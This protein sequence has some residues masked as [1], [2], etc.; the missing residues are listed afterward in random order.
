MSIRKIEENRY[1]IDISLGYVKGKQKRH[2]V[3]FDGS[4][5]YAVIYEIE[6]ARQLGKPS[7]EKRTIAGFSDEYLEWAK[8]H[9][10]E[11]TYKDKKKI[12]FSQIIPFFGNMKPDFITRNVLEAYQTKRVSLK[13][14]IHRAINIELCCL[15]AMTVWAKDHG[16]CIDTLVRIKPLPYKRPIPKVLSIEE[17]V[18]FIQACPPVY[19]AYFLGLYHC[20]M[21]SDEAKHLKWTDIIFDRDCIIVRG[22]GNKERVV[23]MTNTFKI[24]LS[25]LPRS[26]TEVFISPKTKRP[27]GD[28]RKTIN[29]VRKIAGIERHI[30]PH[31]LRHSFAT[32]LHDEGE[33]LITIQ[34]LLGHSDIRTTQIYTHVSSYKASTAAMKLDERF[35]QVSN[36]LSEEKKRKLS[37]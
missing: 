33:S 10:S 31:L 1:R 7:A 21:R 2:Q 20:G 14:K 35:K 32:H 26:H 23:G 3:V 27:M 28:V 12:I 5:E 29:T 13:G 9:L 24:A 25:K 11:K 18:A 16:Y 4:Y 15:S 34:A 30:N 17:T 22:K 8:L 19:V 36:K 6:L 37:A